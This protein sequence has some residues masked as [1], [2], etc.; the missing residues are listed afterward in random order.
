[1]K[2]KIDI[3]AIC[4]YD[5]MCLL[6]EYLANEYEHAFCYGG[7]FDKG[8][9]ECPLKSKIAT[10]DIKEDRFN[11]IPEDTFISNETTEGENK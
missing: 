6:S 11:D 8:C 9:K 4:N 2:V 5:G 3:T 10:I 7:K 1:M